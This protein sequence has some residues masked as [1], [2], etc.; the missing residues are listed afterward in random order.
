[1]V[2]VFK[3]FFES[4]CHQ[5]GLVL[6]ISI[7]FIPPLQRGKSSNQPSVF[8]LDDGQ[9]VGLFITCL[10]ELGNAEL[11]LGSSVEQAEALGEV[12]LLKN[13]L[14]LFTLDQLGIQ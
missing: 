1:M 13:K 5:E 14:V 6:L 9:C 2:D 4:D 8:S 11:M 7:G 3:P 10:M 12:Q